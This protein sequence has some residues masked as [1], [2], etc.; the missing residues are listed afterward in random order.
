HPDLHFIFP[1]AT[2]KAVERN[3]MSHD[4]IKIWRETLLENDFRMNLNDWYKV[5]GFEKKQG[6]INADD[7]SE[8][9]RTLSYKSY[10]SEFKVMIIWMADRLFH[11]AAPKI[12]KILEEP[13]DKSLF[14]LITENQDKI[15]NTILSRTQAV[16]FS[17]LQDEDLML[18]LTGKYG[19]APEEAQRIIPLADG[20]LTLAVKILVKDEDEIFYLEKFITWMRLC[21]LNNLSSNMEF[22][23]EIAKLGREKQ[24][25]FLAYA[26]RIIRNAL[27]INYKNPHLTRLNPEEKDFLAKFGKFINHTNIPAFTEELEKAQFHIERN[28]NP[29]I[30]FM[31]LSM[32]IT[33]LLLSAEKDLA[34]N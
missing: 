20:N 22:I 11:S 33:V 25:N 18:E 21:Y 34:K 13:P 12:L 19:C 16:K 10:E 8:I 32:T 15:I 27:L 9:L 7:C 1:V 4:F 24:K 14:I 5:A 6:I 29:S 30:L 23:G 3:P 2:T 28:A 26:E 31:D 17:K